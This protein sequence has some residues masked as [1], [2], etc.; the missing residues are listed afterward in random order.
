MSD[1]VAWTVDMDIGEGKL[2]ALKALITEMVA[3]TQAKE[4]GALGYQWDITEDGKRLTIRE[5]YKDIAA[6]QAHM[7]NVGPTHIPRLMGMGTV[8]SF[9]VYA[10][11]VTPELRATLAGAHPSFT[12]NAGGFV[13]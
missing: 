4:P 10:D 1:Q 2:K 5:R 13:R 7:G 9:T 11:N 3:Q 8:T 12:Q 6:V